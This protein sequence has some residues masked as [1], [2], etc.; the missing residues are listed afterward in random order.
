VHALFDRA[1]DISDLA[2]GAAMICTAFVIVRRIVD[3]EP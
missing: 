1:P 3:I 2:A